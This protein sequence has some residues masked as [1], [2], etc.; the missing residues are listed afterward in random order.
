MLFSYLVRKLRF[1]YNYKPPLHESSSDKGVQEDKLSNNKINDNL[2]K[3]LDTMKSLFCN[4]N[5]F[6]VHNFRLGGE[7]GIEGA[8]L[9][10]DGLID[11]LLLAQGVLSPLLKK[12]FD[13]KTLPKG[14]ERMQLLKQDILC[15]AEIEEVFSLAELSS[16]IL[17]GDTVLLLDDCETGLI[18]SS[19]GYEMR[20]VSEPQSEVVVK[21]PREGFTEN[22]RTNTALIRRKIRNGNLRVEQMVLGRKTQ[23]QICVVYLA[24]VANPKVIAEVK[25]RLARLDIES[26]LETGYIEEYIEDAPF[27]PFSTVGYTE[28]PDVVAG[29]L[30]EGRVAILVDGTPF[31]LTAP[32]LFAEVFQSS[33]DYYLRPFYASFIRILRYIAFFLTMFGPAFYIA[34]TSFHHELIPITLLFSIAVAREGTPFP[35]FIEALIMVL[36]F[37]IMR[38]AGV[39]LPRA[40]GQ[41]ISIVGALVMGDAAVSAGLVGA[42]VVITI[43]ITAVASFLIP[44]QNDAISLLRLVMMG[45]A[46]FL[47]FYGVTIGLLAML[48]HLASLQ[49]FGI[50]YFDNFN[51]STGVEDT[52]VRAP[53][54][55]MTRRPKGI[56]YDDTTRGRFFIPPIRPHLKDEDEE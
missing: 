8:L 15:V 45:L 51:I 25:G 16:G 18:I 37:E 19:K 50:P 17:L 12:T 47:G 38:E 29:K 5:D 28:K 44:A 52:I 6:K 56:A 31:A 7:S 11:N 1:L 35:V 39:R 21:G 41:A 20:Q 46:A 42:P 30:L 49:S 23:T 33:E 14:S 27:S 32:L 48:I 13:E 2:K 26:V 54:W 36:A 4:S 34:L 9:Y 10:I 43:A 53:L 24:G 40:V 22:I 3:N 55:A